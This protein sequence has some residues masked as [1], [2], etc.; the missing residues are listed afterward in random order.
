VETAGGESKEVRASLLVFDCKKWG[1]RK[2]QGR[3]FCVNL[4]EKQTK[5]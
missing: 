2:T 1:A 3:I 5:Q 4:K